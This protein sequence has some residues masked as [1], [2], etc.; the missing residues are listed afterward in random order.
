VER[1]ARALPVLTACLVLVV[2][3][4]LALQ[5]LTGTV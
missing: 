5:A 1:L 4:G 3:L 2:G